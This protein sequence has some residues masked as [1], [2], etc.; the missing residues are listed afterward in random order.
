MV[1]A[2]RKCAVLLALLAIGMAAT[3]LP[4]YAETQNVKVGGD[5]T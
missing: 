1:K 3:A 2:T 4:S 5:Y